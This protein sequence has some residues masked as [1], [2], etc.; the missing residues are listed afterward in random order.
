MPHIKTGV[1][2]DAFLVSSKTCKQQAS[3][4]VL[5]REVA[6]LAGLIDIS[7]C[8]TLQRAPATRLGFFLETNILCRRSSTDVTNL[9]VH[10]APTLKQ[11]CDVGNELT[12]SKAK[13]NAVSTGFRN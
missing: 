9:R 12:M 5:P 2:Q 3:L 1:T 6:Y 8:A 13:K 10:K 11:K 7:L 4:Q